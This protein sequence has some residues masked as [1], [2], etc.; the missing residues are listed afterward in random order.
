MF[1]IHRPAA[2]ARLIVTLWRQESEPA[3]DSCESET[4]SKHEPP[5]LELT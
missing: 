5:V 3:A 4:L 1:L 2:L